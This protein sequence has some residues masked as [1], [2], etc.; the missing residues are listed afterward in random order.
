MAKEYY[1][2]IRNLLLPKLEENLLSQNVILKSVHDII[3]Q[4][5]KIIESSEL[6]Y[7]SFMHDKKHL[8]SLNPMSHISVFIDTIFLFYAILIHN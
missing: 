8:C 3:N 6:Y 4:E 5:L 7:F 2:K 1:L